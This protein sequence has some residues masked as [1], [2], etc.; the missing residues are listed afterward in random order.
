MDNYT[1]SDADIKGVKDIA[2][3]IAS[4]SFSGIDEEELFQIGIVALLESAKR[5]DESRGEAKLFSFAYLRIRGAMLDFIAKTSVNGIS[6]ISHKLTTST[7]MAVSYGRPADVAHITDSPYQD[8]DAEEQLLDNLAEAEILLEAFQSVV[9]EVADKEL[10]YLERAIVIEYFT[11]NITFVVLSKRYN[12][13]RSRVSK[14]IKRFIEV[15]T[16]HLAETEPRLIED[17]KAL[18]DTTVRS[19]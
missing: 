7:P 13:S 11:H 14:V 18:M 5:Y 17:F 9:V 12:M 8:K 1:P 2:S 16:N 4:R 6:T 15:L 10:T 3:Y 19:F